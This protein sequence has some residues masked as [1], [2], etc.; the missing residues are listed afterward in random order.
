MSKV[1]S[2]KKKAPSKWVRYRNGGDGMIAWAE[3]NVMV[4]MYPPGFTFS[5]WCPMGAASMPATEIEP[6]T[7]KPYRELWTVKHPDTGRSYQDMW[8][9]EKPILR[10]ALEMKN[11]LFVYSLIVFCWPRGEGKSFLAVLIQLWKFCCFLRQDIKFCA[12]SKDQTGHAHYKIAK[13]LILN[14]PNL[15]EHVGGEENV[16]EQEIR[17]RDQNGYV[18]STM[19]VIPTGSG[20]FSN[21]TGYA[22]SEI[23][24][25]KNE[26]FFNKVDGSIRN[27]PNALGVIDSTVSSKDHLLYRLYE[28]RD[29]KGKEKY[30]PLIYFS[31]RHS[32][33]GDYRDYWHPSNTQ[34]QL[35]SYRVKQGPR[36][37]AFFLNLW[38]AG[39][40]RIFSEEDVEAIN[41]MGVD[42]M[43]NHE[44]VIELIRR[45][46]EIVESDRELRDKGVEVYEQDLELEEVQQRFWMVKDVFEYLQG[47]KSHTSYMPVEMLSV[48][49]DIYDTDWAITCGIDRAQPMKRRTAAR[50]IFSTLAKG[51][52]GSRSDPARGLIES[53]PKARS[54]RSVDYV[55]NG[56]EYVYILVHLADVV[57][58]SLRGL[59]DEIEFAFQEYDGIDFIGAENWGVFDLKPTCEDLGIKFDHWTPSYDRQLAAFTEFYSVVASGR[60]KAAPTGISGSRGDD[61]LIEEAG[62]FDQDLEKK[63]FGSPEKNMKYGVQDDSMYSIGWNIFG[64]RFL[65][66]EDFRS[67]AGR[68]FFG[69]M[70]QNNDLLGKYY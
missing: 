41:I 62:M 24:E 19:A 25:L 53:R 4:P 47:P 50:T 34:A 35:N 28:A 56:P 68:R 69:L 37:G 70:V 54:D 2:K 49:S 33:T 17:M 12:N 45:R 64:G 29:P 65:N 40:E 11:G 46:N 20:I 39:S 31:Y 60:F 44:G 3:E 22:F 9:N 8:E 6:I 67:R 57:D 16:Q 63:S 51:L 26:D 15:L 23:F 10:E 58:N 32:K 1:R 42:R 66:V 27:T 30:D 61:I 52:P 36:F 13:N 38:S 14:S 55:A 18:A 5:V 21:I 43:L 7:G 48:L 59:Q